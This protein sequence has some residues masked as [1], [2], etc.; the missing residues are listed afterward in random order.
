MSVLAV[1]PARGGSKRLPRKNIMEFDGKPLIAWTIEAAKSSRCISRVIVSTDDKDIADIAKEYGADVPFMRPIELA[2]DEVTS[3]E[4]VLHL[5]ENLQ[6]NYD[7]IALL[8][9]TSPLRTTEHIDR[10]FAE[11]NGRNAIVSVVKMEHPVEWCN[12]L[13]TN[14]SMDRFISDSVCNKRSQD[15]PQRYRIN[16]AIYIVKTSEF[17]KNNSLY[18]DKTIIYAMSRGRSLEIDTKEDFVKIQAKLK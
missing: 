17:L 3:V 4:V 16:G 15:L 14:N 9:P 12:E 10:A 6:E 18:T 5:L 7:Y 11:L 1:I 8:Q 2:G 13:P